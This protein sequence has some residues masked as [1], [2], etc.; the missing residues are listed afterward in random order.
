MLSPRSVTAAPAAAAPARAAAASSGPVG[1]VSR[2][3]KTCGA[4]GSAARP[5]GGGGCRFSA[6][7]SV[8]SSFWTTARIASASGALAS[9]SAS[10]SHVVGN[11]PPVQSTSFTPL[12]ASGLWLAVIT[13]PHA[14]PVTRERIA[15]SAP[16]R[17][18]VERRVVPTVRNPAVP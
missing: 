18:T 12:S 13:M 17:N 6:G 2:A 5:A 9:A 8:A 4:G 16:Q 10:A 15:A 1:R 11:M 7:S 14:R 3:R